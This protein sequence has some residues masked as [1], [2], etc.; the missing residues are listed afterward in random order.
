MVFGDEI[1]T[2]AVGAAATLPLIYTVVPSLNSVSVVLCAVLMSDI[3][4][5]N[6]QD[7]LKIYFFKKKGKR[8]ES[9]EMAKEEK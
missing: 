1:S 6:R 2:A 3:V 8:R 5:G 9:C 4:D 7:L